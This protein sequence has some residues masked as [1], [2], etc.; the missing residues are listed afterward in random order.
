MTTKE[1]AAAWRAANPDKVR[2]YREKWNAAHPGRAAELLRRWTEENRGRANAES[3]KRYAKNAEARREKARANYVAKQEHFVAKM[4]EWVGASPSLYLW[5]R[6]KERARV[7]GLAFSIEVQDVVV[8][9]RCPVLG[10]ALSR[11]EGKFCPTSP[12]LD[13]IDSTKG[14]VKGNVVVVSWR[15]NRLKSDATLDELRA[16]VRFYERLA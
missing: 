10:C 2:A 5:R 11:G 1:Y 6:A 3:R 4:R 12:T 8:P 13:R 15:A 16:I 9:A 7:K 14:Y